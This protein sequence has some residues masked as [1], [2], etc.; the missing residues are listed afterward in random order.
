MEISW[1]D[2]VRNEDVLLTVNEQRNIL[3]TIEGMNANWFGH[4]LRR[5]CL[6]KHK[7]KV[8]IEGGIEVTERRG[9]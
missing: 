4:F 7:I 5:N 2:G 8:K 3:H 6:L 1:T 9:R